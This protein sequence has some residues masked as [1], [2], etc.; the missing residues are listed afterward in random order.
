MSPDADGNFM[1]KCGVETITPNWFKEGLPSN[2]LY[3]VC[4][5]TSKYRILI[6]LLCI[7][8]SPM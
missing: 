6:V 5:S 7:F 1:A 2:M 3:D 8:A 4:A